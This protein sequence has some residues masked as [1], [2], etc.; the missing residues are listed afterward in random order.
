MHSLETE[1]F[2]NDIESHQSLITELSTLPGNCTT[3]EARL[4]DCE[5]A[6]YTRSGRIEI[7]LNNAWGTVCN[8]SFDDKDAAVTCTQLEGFVSEGK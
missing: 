7:C 5:D 8:T 1:I 3:G 2:V 4:A 6:N